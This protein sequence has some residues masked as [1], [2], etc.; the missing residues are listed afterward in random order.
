[1]STTL[2][3]PGV[4]SSITDNSV[5]VS[6]QGATIPLFY[7]ATAD[8]KFQADGITP[9]LG[10]YEYGVLRTVTS[11]Q[12]ALQ[13]YGVPRFLTDA[14]GNPFHGDCR[15]EYGLDALM[16]ALTVSNMAYVIRA[17]VNLNDDITDLKALWTRQLQDASGYLNVLVQDFITQYNAANNL[18][19]I[20]ANYKVT[21]TAAELTVLVSEALSNVLGMYSFSSQLF[22]NAFIQDHTQAQAGY[23]DVLFDT[24]HGYLQLSDATGYVPTSTYGAAIDIVGTGGSESYEIHITG[25]QAPTFGDLIDE[26][27]TVI[28]A[29]GSASLVAGSLR[30]IS[31]LTGATSE[32][33][34]TSDGPSATLPLFG[35][36]NLY[37]ELGVPV[38]G[39]GAASLNVYN[40]SYSTVIGTYDGLDNAINSWTDGS[41][42]PDE[43]TASEAEGVLLA[44]SGLYEDT[45]EFKNYSALGSNDAARR[46]TIVKQL[47][48]I[49]ASPTTG[50]TSESVQ[51]DVVACPGYSECTNALVVLSQSIRSEVFVV[52][53][54]PLALP[55][56]GPNG[57]TTWATTPARVNNYVNGYWFGHGISSNIDGADIMSTAASTA[58]RTILYSDSVAQKWY[59]PAGATRGTCPQLTNLGYVS[60]TL[61]GPTTFVTDYL[62]QGERDALYQAPVNVNPITY[63]PGRGILVFGE[64]SSSPITSALDRINVVRLTMYIQRQLRQALFAFLFE[65]NDAKTWNNVSYVANTFLNGLVA[66]RGLYDFLVIC[67]GTNNTPQTID[68]NE[69]HIQLLIAPTKDVEFI[70]MDIT[71]VNTGTNLAQFASGASIVPTSSTGV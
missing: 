5:Y 64:K 36:L 49:I 7:I 2:V 13:L 58:V 60:G 35:S 52:G 54:T 8:E 67:D 21:V 27:N 42:V 45:K 19:P 59:A 39:V 41:V 25:S 71:L 28:N 63:I 15:N 65:P 38:V 69:L 6:D 55:P 70:Y 66:R 50:A 62:D 26:I 47:N 24:S 9:A 56:V 43:F 40:D 31:N 32:V 44:A 30:V 10:T 37:K 29:S 51:Y 46:A 61:G 11:I 1:M 53:E 16:K 4:S 23:Q 18:I 3:S 68:N 48:A 34:I 17:N 33:S 20:D 22:Q 14:A 12:Q 57:I